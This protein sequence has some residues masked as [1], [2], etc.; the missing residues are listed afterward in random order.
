MHGLTITCLS[1]L[2]M[3]RATLLIAFSCKADVIAVID[4][5]LA[6]LVSRVFLRH[7]LITKPNEHPGTLRSDLPRKW[8]NLEAIMDLNPPFM[9]EIFMQRNISYSLR[10]G[11]DAQLPKVRTTSFGVESIAYLGNKLWQIVP[12]EIKQSNSLPIFKKQIRCWNGGKCNCRLCKVYI[13]KV[14]FL[15]W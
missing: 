13:P 6:N 11:D 3:N 14:E 7:T 8:G 12:Q 15:T 4:I 9:K 1:L 2:P 10:H 5:L